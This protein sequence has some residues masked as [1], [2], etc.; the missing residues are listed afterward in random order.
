M[1]KKIKEKVIICIPIYVIQLFQEF[2]LLIN[3]QV[4]M[5]LREKYIVVKEYLKYLFLNEKKKSNF[6]K[7]KEIFK[8]I[9]SVN[10]II[11]SF[12]VYLGSNKK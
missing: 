9:V 4:N 11:Y 10:T 3:I 2:C 7:I 8:I 12:T 6:K 1:K 5:I